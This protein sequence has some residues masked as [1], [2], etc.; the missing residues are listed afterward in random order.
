MRK[1][2]VNGVLVG[3]VLH[4]RTASGNAYRT[5]KFLH[6]FARRWGQTA[7]LLGEGKGEGQ[8]KQARR[9]GIQAKPQGLSPNG[10]VGPKD[11][12]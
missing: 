1:T 8:A 5:D 12:E 9:R 6:L 2:A 3:S 11:V 7:D 4:H 10:R